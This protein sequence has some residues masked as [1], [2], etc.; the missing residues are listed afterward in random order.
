M[1]MTPSTA[2]RSG[3]LGRLFQNGTRW[4]RITKTTRVWVASDSTNH[5]ERNSA[6]PGVEGAEHDR[7]GGEVEERADRP[8]G[9]HEPSDELDVP[10][11]GAGEQLGVDEVGGDGHLAGVVEEVV[12]QDLAREH[13]QERQ[14]RGGDRGAEHVPEV[15]RRAHEHVLD[16]VRERAASFADAVGEHAEVL[17]EQDDVGGVLG[18][19]GG[20]LDGDP[21]VGGVERDGVVDAVAEERD[22][23]VG[24]AVRAD[25]P[26]LLLGTDPGE[27]RRVDDAASAA[28]RRRARR[29]RRRSSWP[30]DVEAEV[31]TDL[32]GDDGV[33]AGDDLDGDA[34]LGEP[35]ERRG[36]VELG[37]VEE[38][39]VARRA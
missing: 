20:G 35:L 32:L 37:L 18:D 31:A 3:R 22:V 11:R 13:G 30:R 26:G 2:N 29:S 23:A 36:G 12:E 34:E 14:E 27:D 15:R 7:E 33:V 5:P 8:E 38:D 6:G 25:E 1:V 17:L 10:V 21:D 16:R 39:E 19:V 4:V 9:E 28:R 24:G